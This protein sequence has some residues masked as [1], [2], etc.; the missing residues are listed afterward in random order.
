VGFLLRVS[1]QLV[2][3][4]A[5]A[6][7]EVTSLE[8]KVGDHLLIKMKISLNPRI[9]FYDRKISNAYSVEN[10]VLEVQRLA[11]LADTLLTYLDNYTLIISIF[12]KQIFSNLTSAQSTEV[13]SGLGDDVSEKLKYNVLI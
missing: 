1:G 5:V 2:L 12:K 11:R 7:G 3:T 4:S 13:L 9:L 6:S 8:H 10:A